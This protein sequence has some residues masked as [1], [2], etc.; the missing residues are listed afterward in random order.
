MAL[1][2]S[3]NCQIFMKFGIDIVYKKL[4]SKQKYHKNQLSKPHFIY[5]YKHISTCNIHIYRLIWLKFGTNLHVMPFSKI[6]I[7]G[8]WHTDGY[9]L[10]VDVNGII[11]CMCHQTI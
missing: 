4:L 8:N 3:L 11:L 2:E 10:L 7:C 1:S 9:T 6:E 5:G